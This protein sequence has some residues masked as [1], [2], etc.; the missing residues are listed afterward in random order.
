MAAIADKTGRK[1]LVAGQVYMH[2]IEDTN[3]F[4]EQATL[5]QHSSENA[6]QQMIDRAKEMFRNNTFPDERVVGDPFI[7]EKVPQPASQQQLLQD[8]AQLDT[9]MVALGKQI[10]QNTS[11]GKTAHPGLGFFSA[12]EWFQYA[13]MHL[14]HHERQQGRIINF[15]RANALWPS[16]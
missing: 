9:R 7:S 1:E 3:W 16:N 2:V 5:C 14:R 4:A 15:L 13:E 11:I 6:W 8:L 10:A 12:Q